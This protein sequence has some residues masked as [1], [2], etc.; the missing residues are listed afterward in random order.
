MA[1]P[2]IPPQEIMASQDSC[3]SDLAEKLSVR[4]SDVPNGQVAPTVDY[5]DDGDIF[6]LGFEDPF[7]GLDPKN[8]QIVA[9][10]NNTWKLFRRSHRLDD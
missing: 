6:G 10:A 7:S 1:D 8:K 2:E 9:E 3:V 5:D 4:L